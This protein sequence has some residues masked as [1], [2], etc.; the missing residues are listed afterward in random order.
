MSE[1]TRH[2]PVEWIRLLGLT[3]SAGLVAGAAISV[4]AY[5]VARYGP[6][7]DSWSFRGNGALAVYALIP[8]VL[9]AGW[10]ALVLNARSDRRWLGF[11]LAAGLLG[12]LLAAIDA[13]LLPTFGPRGDM[14]AGPILLFGLLAWMVLAPVLAL[15]RRGGTDRPSASVARYLGGGAVWFAATIIGLFAAGAIAP[16]GS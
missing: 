5:Y 8:A 16:A 4:L 7:G 12:A 13:A 11:G 2:S 10:T 3:M 9:A 15:V 14:V 6:S 1:R